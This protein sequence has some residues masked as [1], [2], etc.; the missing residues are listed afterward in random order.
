MKRYFFMEQDKRLLDCISLRDFDV[1][2][3]R[4]VFRKSDA[5]DI[6][7]TTILYLK[8]NSGETGQDF[9]Q[10]PATMVSKMVKDVFY[11]YQ[12]DIIF[13]KV[14]VIGKEEKT[15]LIYYIPLMDEIECMSD[16]VLRYPNGMEKSVVLDRERVGT[17]RVFLLKDS[18]VKRPVVSIEVVE[19]L[20]RRNQVGIIFQEVEVK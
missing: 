11:M 7:D 10:S 8:K 6:N 19:S 3:S 2:G 14:I 17:N 16:S 1:K 12:E 15:Q 9:F 13:K 4:M 18:M 20:L 5:K